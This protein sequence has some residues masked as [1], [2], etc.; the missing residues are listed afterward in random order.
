MLRGTRGRDVICG[1]G[2]NDL[3]LGLGGNDVLIGGAGNDTLRGGAGKDNLLG[4]AGNDVLRGEDG[5]DKLDGFGGK[6]RLFGG[7]GAD[8]LNGGAGNDYLNGGAGRDVHQGGGGQGLP[9]RPRQG[10]RQRRRPG[11]SR[12]RPLHD[13]LHQDVPVMRA[14]PR[15]ARLAVM[16]LLG[17]VLCASAYLVDAR[18]ID[19]GCVPVIRVLANGDPATTDGA[20]RVTVDGLG[21]FGRG[22]AAGDAVFNPPGASAGAL[23][24][25]F[26]SNL[27]LNAA[28]RLLADDCN[29]QTVQVISES[30]LH[31]RTFVSGL[32][33]DLTQELAPVALG[34]STLTQDYTFALAPGNASGESAA[35]DP[36]APPGRGPPVQQPRDLGRSGGRRRHAV[37][38]RLCRRIAAPRLPGALRRP[39]WQR[40]AEPV[41]DSAV[42]LQAGDR[43]CGRD[44]A[45]RSRHRSSTTPTRTSTPTRPSTPR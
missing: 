37:R 9:L 6:D 34:G 29:G 17:A 42:R 14:R 10:A 44:P 43:R 5:H 16:A 23:G 26:T 21:A 1:L 31:T 32:Q 25:T 2:G 30:P 38:V 22:T 3:I 12:G 28:Q 20:V 8:V 36:G 45:G 24:T 19:D 7:R 4:D 13:R 39:R 35:T 27:Y 33:I 41:D 40:H 15:I 18:A 11:R